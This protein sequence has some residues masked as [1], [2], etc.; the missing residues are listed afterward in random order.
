MDISLPP[1]S[2]LPRPVDPVVGQD[3]IHSNQEHAAVVDGLVKAVKQKVEFGRI[4]SPRRDK[5]ANTRSR[6]C[7]CVLGGPASGHCG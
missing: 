4:Q 3:W 5:R 6:G 1:G 7:T 2:S